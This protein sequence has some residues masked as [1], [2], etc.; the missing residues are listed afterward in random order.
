MTNQLSGS[1]SY[2]RTEITY[3]LFGVVYSPLNYAQWCHNCSKCWHVPC[4]EDS[5]SLNGLVFCKQSTHR[6]FF[7]CWVLLLYSMSINHAIMPFSS[8]IHTEII[9]SASLESTSITAAA[10]AST[11]TESTTAIASATSVYTSASTTS[12]S[13]STEST[14]VKAAILLLLLLTTR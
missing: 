8:Q 5:D 12:T 11:T 14:S 1:D 9:V 7:S 2:K 4:S 13:A 3:C 10:A 6:L